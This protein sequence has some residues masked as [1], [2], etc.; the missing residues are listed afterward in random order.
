MKETTLKSKYSVVRKVL[1]KRLHKASPSIIKRIVD[2]K[3]EEKN[4]KE[5]RDTSRINH[6]ILNHKHI[7]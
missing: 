2:A 6:V 5:L 7:T 4:V 3:G 1:Q